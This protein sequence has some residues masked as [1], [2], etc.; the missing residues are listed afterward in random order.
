MFRFAFE[1]LIEAIG[2]KYE[3]KTQDWFPHNNGSEGKGDP[4]VAFSMLDAILKG[5]LERLKLMRSD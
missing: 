3:Q 1:D 5:S 4:E 2:S